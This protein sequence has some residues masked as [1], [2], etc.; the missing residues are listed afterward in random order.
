MQALRLPGAVGCIFVADWEILEGDEAIRL[1]QDCSRI[2][3]LVLLASLV[4]AVS[5]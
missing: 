4:A 1:S 2:V 3:D 5:G